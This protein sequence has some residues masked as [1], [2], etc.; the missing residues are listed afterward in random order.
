M[1]RNTETWTCVSRNWQV[2]LILSLACLAGYFQHMGFYEGCPWWNH[3]AYSFCH[4]NLWHLAVNL[5]VLWS[6]RNR[7]PIAEAFGVAVAASFLPM[8]V[9]ESTMGL[10]GFLFGCF[11][12]MWGKTGRWK[13]AFVKAMP[14]IVCTMIMPNVNGLLHLYA[15]WLGYIVAFIGRG[16]KH[17]NRFLSF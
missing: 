17:N 7:I 13:D 2:K 6:I 3:F 5:M 16:F 11:G 4:A 12:C 8:Y 14:F 10:S 9:S 1:G 15:F